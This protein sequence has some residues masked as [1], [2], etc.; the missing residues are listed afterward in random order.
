MHISLFH[1]KSQL[2]LLLSD[3]T[4]GHKKA[5]TALSPVCLCATLPGLGG[6]GQ[7]LLKE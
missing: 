5:F 3:Q 7:L 2:Q 4:D 6:R 1:V